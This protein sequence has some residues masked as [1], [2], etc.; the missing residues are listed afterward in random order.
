M[1]KAVIEG[2]FDLTAA[3]SERVFPGSADVAGLTNL[4]A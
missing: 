2:T 4:M 1:L 3:Q